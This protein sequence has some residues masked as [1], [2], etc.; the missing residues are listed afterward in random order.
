LHLSYAGIDFQILRILE[1]VR[2]AVTDESGADF[3]YDQVG[4]RCLT[5]LNPDATTMA[6][7][8]AAGAAG[9]AGQLLG[10]RASPAATEVELVSRLV[11][12]RQKLFV[13]MDS[14]LTDDVNPQE[15]ILESPLPGFTTDA[16][17]GPLC[18]VHGLQTNHGNASLVADL[19]FV[20]W[21]N[22]CTGRPGELPSPLL[23]NRWTYRS[24]YNEAYA[25]VREFDGTAIFRLDALLADPVLKG[26]A[27]AFRGF[28]IPPCPPG[29]QR[30]APVF[31]LAPAGDALRY[32]ITD[33]RQP[34]SFPGAVGFDV[35]HIEVIEDRAYS[36]PIDFGAGADLLG[37]A[38]EWAKDWWSRNNPF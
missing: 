15:T 29:Y 21:L 34:M 25:E 30:E 9:A 2:T 18:V 36:T 20:T 26:D 8:P 1:W 7:F 27:S 4:I 24:T 22:P 28:L 37:R 13:W 38:T 16:R 10:G 35:A 31:E 12:P 11:Q 32:K 14:S 19:E 3:L 6:D 33:T 5:W 23:S 17:Y